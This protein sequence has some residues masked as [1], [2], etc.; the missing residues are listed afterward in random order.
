[1]PDWKKSARPPSKSGY[2]SICDRQLTVDQVQILIAGSAAESQE[3]QQDLWLVASQLNLECT[4]AEEITV[5]NGIISHKP[6]KKS[7]PLWRF[8]TEASYRWRPQKT[9]TLKDPKDF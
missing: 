5:E 7:G 6:A 2:A 8:V 4:P 9:V 1:M 3:L